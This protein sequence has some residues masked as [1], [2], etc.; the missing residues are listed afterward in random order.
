MQLVSAQEILVFLP[1][2]QQ[3]ED[4]ETR[5]NSCAWLAQA[6]A[7]SYAGISFAPYT[8]QTVPAD[9]KSALIKWSL[10][11]YIANETNTN[12]APAEGGFA[13]RGAQHLK[14]A[15]ELLDRYR[16]PVAL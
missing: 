16:P 7:E 14:E 10:A 15:K 5:L 13:D 9:I 12:F 11:E 8:P 2:E 4:T 1:N 3:T 6:Q